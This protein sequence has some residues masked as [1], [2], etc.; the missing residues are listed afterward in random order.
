[1]PYEWKQTLQE[2]SVSVPVPKGTRAKMLNVKIS[3]SKLYVALK[4]EKP[5]I[6]ACCL[7]WFDRE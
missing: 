3:K 4:G 6:D 5:L 2:V 7:V 1:V